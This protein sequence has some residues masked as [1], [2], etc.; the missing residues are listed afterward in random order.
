VLSLL[1]ERIGAVALATT[2]TP[3]VHVATAEVSELTMTLSAVT[4]PKITDGVK[5]E[6]MKSVPVNY[7]LPALAIVAFVMTG[8]PTS[9]DW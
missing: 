7:M 1:K 3:L 4:P 6:V 2:G 5:P 9:V 8:I